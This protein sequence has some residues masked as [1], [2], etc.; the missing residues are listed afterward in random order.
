[1]GRARGSVY[2]LDAFHA[3]TT[4]SVMLRDPRRLA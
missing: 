4:T 1:M 2:F 3:G